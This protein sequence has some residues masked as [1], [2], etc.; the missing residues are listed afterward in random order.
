MQYLFPSICCPEPQPLFLSVPTFFG[1]NS[2]Q[3]TALHDVIFSCPDF[4]MSA[5]CRVEKNNGKML[6]SAIHN[7]RV[8]HRHS[9]RLSIFYRFD[10]ISFM[11]FHFTIFFGGLVFHC[12]AWSSCGE[13]S[14]LQYVYVC[15]I[16]TV[17]AMLDVLQQMSS[18]LPEGN[19]V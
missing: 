3:L 7:I 13:I 4:L 1:L 14:V 5:T 12:C 2:E 9:V 18:V 8:S 6:L 19:L 16:V 10:L 11:L 17:H 15:V